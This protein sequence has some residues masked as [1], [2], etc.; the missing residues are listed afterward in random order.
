MQAEK[1]WLYEARKM[2]D[3]TPEQCAS[4]IR[5]SRTTYLKREAEPGTLQLNEMQGLTRIYNA[6]SMKIMADVVNDLTCP[7]GLSHA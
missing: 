5:R 7:Q 3:L 1:T 2:S 6:Q 4:A